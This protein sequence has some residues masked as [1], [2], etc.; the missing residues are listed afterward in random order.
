M[1]L[2]TTNVAIP[3]Q[4][5]VDVL[6]LENIPSPISENDHISQTQFQKVDLD[7]LD[8]D[9]RT[10]K[11]IWEYHVNQRDEIRRAY[12]ENGP[13][14]PPLETYKKSG[15]HN[16]NFQAFWFEYYSTWLEYFP[17][18]DAAYCLPYFVFHKPNGLLGQNAF[19]VGGFR[20]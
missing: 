15:K 11:Q 16:L 13:H 12:I 2:P 8:F 20:N 17:T 3:I 19:T 9:P 7:F 14:Q 1:G 5:N 10:R 18:K 6:I 4:E